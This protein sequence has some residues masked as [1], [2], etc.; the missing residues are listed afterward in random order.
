MILPA[1][2]LSKN[3]LSKIKP[4]LLAYLAV[5]LLILST[6]VYAFLVHGSVLGQYNKMALS[7][8]V[9]VDFKQKGVK[10]ASTAE[11]NSVSDDPSQSVNTN[12]VVKPPVRAAS[13]TARVYPSIDS[14]GSSE[15][16][17]TAPVIV[18]D[19]PAAG[20]GDSE[21]DPKTLKCT[22][23]NEGVQNSIHCKGALNF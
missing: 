11:S 8:S 13:S 14:Q 22:L 5:A 3:Q 7:F 4:E 23:N 20:G 15:T 2:S 21:P 17:N 10:A 12:S 18:Q 16:T 19:P 1:I 9:P 6:A